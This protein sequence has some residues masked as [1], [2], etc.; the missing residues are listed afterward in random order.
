MTPSTSVPTT[1][2]GLFDPIPADRTAIVL[3]EQNIRVSYGELRRQVQDL[4]EA[5]AG[6]RHPPRRP[7]G[8]GP[9]QQSVDDRLVPGRVGGG[10]RRAA[11]PRLQGRRVPF[12]PRGHQRQGAA[13]AARRRGRGPRGR[14]SRA[15]PD[16]GDEPE[17]RGVAPR[18]VGTHAGRRTGASTMWRSS[19][20]R[21]AAPDG[22]SA[23]RSATPTSP[24]RRRTSRAATRSAAEDV[25][26][27]VMPLFHVHGLVASTLAHAGHRRHGGRAGEV[28][29]AVVLAH[30][31][32]QR[33]HLV[34]GRS[35]DP[36]AAARACASRG[37]RGRRAPR[38]CGSSVRAAPRCR[39]R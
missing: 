21:A 17:R 35:D 5:L 10:H 27:C 31:P 6:I 19:C 18:R 38:S 39:R 4:A 15:D 22:R 1:L 3:P 13:A 34:F 25:S 12:L 2:A 16:G 9:P 23:C 7:R 28:L 24:S 30:R 32:R 36:P 33:G 8:H 37:T 11:Q 29:A 20:T 14:R 26:L